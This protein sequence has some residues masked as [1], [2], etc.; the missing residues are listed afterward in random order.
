MSAVAGETKIISLYQSQKKIYTKSVKGR[1]ARWRVAM[2]LLTQALFYG[3]AW[4]PWNGRQAVLFDLTARKFYIFGWVFWPQDVL[5]LALILIVSA[6]A[7]F[8]VTAI[9]GR[10]FCGYACPQTVYTEI[11]MWIEEKLEGD[12]GARMRLDLAP[13]SAKK[14]WRKGG[15]HL[16]WILVALWTGF[17]FVG[18]FTPIRALVR[19]LLSVSMGPWETF[20]IAFYSF[21]TWGNAGFMREQ[22]CKY[23]CPYARFQSVMFDRDTM[24]V[25]YDQARGEPRGGRKRNADASAKNLG[26]CVDCSLCVQVCPTGIDIRDGLQYECIGCSA[27]VDI[28]DTVMDKMNYPRGLV[29][30][31]T[32]NA[33]ADKRDAGLMRK[34]LLRPR[35]IIYCGVLLL[36]VGGLLVS[37]AL[38]NPLKVDVIRDKRVLAREIDGRY[39]EN[40]YKLNVMN[41]AEKAQ[42]FTISVDGLTGIRVDRGSTI[43]AEPAST[44]ASALAVRIPLEVAAQAKPGSHA[45]HL[46]I[47]SETDPTASVREKT[48][49]LIPR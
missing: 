44:A 6:Y 38:R 48:T 42:R 5:Y 23:M 34:R 4:L 45:I 36:L 40:I 37:L 32:E 31:S 9:A 14:L 10:V 15:K 28:C 12:R 29:R 43:D 18:Y 3:L 21:A 7:L 47:T 20:W 24:I 26:S 17:T 22:V 39:I 13:M 49:F 11:F 1:F 41:T 2:V 35:I 16:L 25:T 27:C 8:F 19:E 33:I 30:Y 46:S